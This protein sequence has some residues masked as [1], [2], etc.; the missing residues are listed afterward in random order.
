VINDPENPTNFPSYTTNNIRNFMLN[1]EPP[2]DNYC[3]PLMCEGERSN[4]SELWTLQFDGAC[5]KEGNGASVLLISP[6]GREFPH[7]F[8]LEF[9]CT[10]NVAEY[11]VLML[12]LETTRKDGGETTQDIWR[13]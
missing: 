9:E 10:N 1:H 13:L 6:K 5:N 7:G 12:G 4:P 2:V 8:K 3:I 11:E